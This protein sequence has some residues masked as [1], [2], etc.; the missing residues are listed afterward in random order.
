MAKN[1]TEIKEE[2]RLEKLKVVGEEKVRKKKRE[3]KELQKELRRLKARKFI[4]VGRGI[5]R[6]IKSTG[7]AISTAGRVIKKAAPKPRT[8]EQQKRDKEFMDMALGM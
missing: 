6:G 5:K 2:I 4:S 3:R 1:I 7:S 8:L